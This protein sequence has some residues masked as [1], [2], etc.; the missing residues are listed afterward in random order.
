MKVTT[1]VR[2]DPSELRSLVWSHMI[3]SLS[4]KELGDTGEETLRFVVDEHGEVEAVIELAR[5]VK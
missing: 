3:E 2:L 4:Q 1:T 5:E